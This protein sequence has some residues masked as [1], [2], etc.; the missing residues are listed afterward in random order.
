MKRIKGFSSVFLSVSILSIMFIFVQCTFDPPQSKKVK[1]TM[2]EALIKIA[3]EVNKNSP[4]MI[5]RDTRF[6]NA[7]SL[8]DN[9]FQYNYTLVNMEKSAVDTVEIITY[10]TPILINNA[11]TN[12]DMKAFLQSEVTLSY[13]YKDKNGNYLFKIFV[14]PSQYQNQEK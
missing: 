5:D 1:L 11:R 10:L 7:I 12:P 6:D 9:I 4:L 13:S 2:E 8:P 3:N 14:T